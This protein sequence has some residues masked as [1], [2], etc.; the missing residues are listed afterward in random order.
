MIN[1]YRLDYNLENG[2]VDFRPIPIPMSPQPTLTP[3]D[4]DDPDADE[5]EIVPSGAAGPKESAQ[6]SVVP[7]HPST[8]TEVPPPPPPSVLPAPVVPVG[9]PI[10]DNSKQTS[11]SSRKNGQE[12]QPV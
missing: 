1:P 9:N 7:V 5:L 11:S 2:D 4:D 12:K 10:A 6:E 3:V 8:Q